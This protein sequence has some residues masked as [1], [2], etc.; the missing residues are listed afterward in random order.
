LKVR[1]I[2]DFFPGPARRTH[3]PPDSPQKSE[4]YPPFLPS[5]LPPPLQM[6]A[7]AGEVCNDAANITALRCKP[8]LTCLP[9]ASLGATSDGRCFDP[10]DAVAFVPL[11]IVVFTLTVVLF[12]MCCVWAYRRRI[13]QAI[14]AERR[15]REKA[16]KARGPPTNPGRPPGGG[17]GA[18]PTPPH[19]APTGAEGGPGAV[20][21]STLSPLHVHQGKS[22]LRATRAMSM[23]S[24]HFSPDLDLA[25]GHGVGLTSG[26][27]VPPAASGG[28]V[29]VTLAVAAVCPCA[30]AG[31][32]ALLGFALPRSPGALQPRAP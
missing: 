28:K 3:D 5:S 21:V 8:K 30:C 24:I 12:T 16:A 22:P 14:A 26:L 27:A 15:R 32:G 31:R 20:A 4:S 10:S 11:F 29:R 7:S 23:P 6:S 18:P 9:L 25:A 1:R 17:L 13:Q 2:G 19:A